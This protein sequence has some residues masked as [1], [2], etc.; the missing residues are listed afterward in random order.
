MARR[1]PGRAIAGRYL[2]Q[3]PGAGLPYQA[4]AEI[5][6][7]LVLIVFTDDV[8]LDAGR[9]LEREVKLRAPDANI[10]Y[11]DPRLSAGMSRA[12][13]EAAGSWADLDIDAIVADIYRAR[14]EGSRPPRRS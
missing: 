13:E 8:R 6:N 3:G 14:E 10:I 11:T 7:R 5:R 12:I 4:Q 1:L 2:C 9:V